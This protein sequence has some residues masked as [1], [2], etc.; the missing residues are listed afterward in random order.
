MRSHYIAG[1][2]IEGRKFV[3]IVSPHTGKPV[4]ESS[5]GV[6]EEVSLAVDAARAALP[7][8]RALSVGERCVYLEKLAEQ[9]KLGY[10]E[11]GESTAL[12]RLIMDAVGKP[13]P[14][15]DIEVIESA[16]F[17]DYFSSIAI[18]TL[19]PRD[20]QLNGDLWPTKRST[21][22]FEPVG[23]VGIIKPWNY[24]LEMPVWSLAPALLAG[25]TVVLKPSE[26]SPSVGEAIARMVESAGFPP[27][28]VNVVA[29]DKSTG[30]LL[31][32]NPGTSMIAFTGSVAAGREVA[33]KCGRLLKRVTLELG[34]NDAAI[35]LPDVD[36]DLAVN[37][38]T[39]GAFCNAGQVCVGVKRVVVVK[40]VAD[41]LIQKLTAR[42]KELRLGIDVGPLIDKK[43]LDAVTKM[44]D[45]AIAEGAKLECGGYR[46]LGLEGFYFHP[47]ILTSLQPTATL[48]L[49]ECFGPVMPIVIVDDAA[50]AVAEANRSNYGLGAS[51]WT[52]DLLAAETLAKQLRVGMVWINDVNVAFA[53]A[54]WGGTR[55][56]GIGFDLSPEAMLEFVTRKHLNVET[57]NDT[58]RFWWYPYKDSSQ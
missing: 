24:P 19:A 2:W 12:K 30:E 8:W 5:I 39:W 3:P 47:T 29:G 28:V 33:E 17:I 13:L 50:A 1:K 48:L 49:E 15:A 53:E 20:I 43:Q 27:G 4:G 42:A 36:L 14:E 18:E 51:V 38:L 40:S 55:D 37:G 41:Q 31:V 34:G 11:E 16:S 56:S 46:D 44:V 7:D 58:R 23:V 32:A 35:V 25:N 21:V 45:L 57:S 6:A 54:P 26:K 52:T 9:L 22:L 10:G